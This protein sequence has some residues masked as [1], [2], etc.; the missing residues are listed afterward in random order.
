MKKLM[1][2]FSMVL[3]GLS[4]GQNLGDARGKVVDKSN[5]IPLEGVTVTIKGNGIERKA[6]TDSIGNY[7]FRGIPAGSYAIDMSLSFYGKASG[8]IEVT[9]TSTSVIPAVE[10]EFGAEIEVVVVRPSHFDVGKIDHM[11]IGVAEI[12]QSSA[13]NDLKTMVEA[14]TPGVTQTPS[15]QLYFKGSRADASGYYLDGV[16][17]DKMPTVPSS[18]LGGI[19]VYTTGL[20]AQY[21]DVTG[22][23]VVVRTK[24][25][26]DLFHERNR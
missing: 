10:L 13:K 18:S 22:G 24:T 9:A 25:Y 1:T 26:F 17:M 6:L 3:V 14:Y 4:F 20:P 21:G 15:G 19:Q 7:D 8:Y 5:K 2:M 11:E 23:V 16:K 12:A